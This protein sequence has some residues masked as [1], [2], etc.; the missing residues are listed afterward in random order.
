[1]MDFFHGHTDWAIELGEDIFYNVQ[2]VY[3]SSHPFTMGIGSLLF[4]MYAATGDQVATQAVIEDVSQLK[5][6]DV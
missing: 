3:G 5:R 2:R 1:M 6:P 4:T